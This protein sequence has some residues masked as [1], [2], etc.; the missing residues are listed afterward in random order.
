MRL[1]VTSLPA[2]MVRT[3]TDLSRSRGT[4][5]PVETPCL[6]PM[7]RVEAPHRLGPSGQVETTGQATMGQ[8]EATFLPPLAQV[9]TIPLRLDRGYRLTHIPTTTLLQSPQCNM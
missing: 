5:G 7:G 9:E 4:N 6:I 1:L 8:V 2:P 3:T